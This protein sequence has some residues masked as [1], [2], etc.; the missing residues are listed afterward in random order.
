MGKEFLFDE[1]SKGTRQF[2]YNIPDGFEVKIYRDYVDTVP[3][4]DS[5]SIFGLHENADLTF[6][7][8]ESSEMLLTIGMTQ[9]REGSG[10]S[11]KGRN[12]IVKDICNNLAQKVP[13]DYVMVEVLDD[14]RK[15]GGP[16]NS[17]DKG[18]K[19]PL[20]N[21]LNQEITRMQLVI[22]VV[23]RLLS[24]IVQ[25]I[26]GLIIMTPEIVDAIDSLFDARVPREWVYNAVGVEISWLI[27][28]LGSW[29]SDLQD[30]C[31]QLTNWLKNPQARPHTFWLTGFFNPQGFLTSMRQ[32][33]TRLHA[34]D[35][36]ALDDMMDETSVTQYENAEK[37][38]DSPTEGVY[39]RG[40]YLEGAKWSKGSQGQLE[41][42]DGKATY[43]EMPIIHYS[44]RKS[45]KSKG[46]NQ[47]NFGQY[48]CPVYKYQCRTDKYFICNINLTSPGPAIHWKLRGVA[49][50]CSVD[51]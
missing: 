10:S 51:S 18:K 43:K 15:L 49:L 6:R 31:A 37:V 50:L 45:D 27:P 8:R 35:E 47:E 5:P 38:R 26:D 16:K 41:E 3:D 11:G 4:K 46:Q 48:V 29:F 32:E 20:N 22:D 34:K 24:E 19:V 40:L 2:Q 12:E 44:A 23:N 36:W 25:A 21:F 33:V 30:R 39:I 14:I 9:P 28:A 7:R 17:T 42:L 1:H 13:P